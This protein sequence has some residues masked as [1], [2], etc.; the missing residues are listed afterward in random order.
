MLE[1]PSDALVLFGASGDLAAKMIYPALQELQAN[2]RLMVPIIGVGRAGWD[3]ARFVAT[4]RLLHLFR[5]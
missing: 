4:T 1:A 2:G 5:A 3:H